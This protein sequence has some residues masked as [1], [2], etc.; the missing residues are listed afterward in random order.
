MTHVR[1][2]ARRYQSLLIKGHMMAVARARLVPTEPRHHL[3][4][5]LSQRLLRLV[6]AAYVP[7][8]YN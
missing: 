8:A 1:G 5:A 4:R 3:S 7:S 6:C 2:V